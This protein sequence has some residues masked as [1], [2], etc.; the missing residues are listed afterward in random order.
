MIIAAKI[1]ARCGLRSDV[2]V[3]SRLLYFSALVDF[4]R[5]VDEDFSFE[6]LRVYSNNV[7][8]LRII[9]FDVN[10]IDRTIGAELHINPNL[11]PE[12]NEGYR[13]IRL[14]NYIVYDDAN[15]CLGR[16]ISV[17]NFG[18]GEILRVGSN[19]NFEYYPASHIEKIEE[20]RVILRRIA[21]A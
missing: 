12:D 21:F 8:L 19:S 14:L 16:V 7:H 20:E 6:Y 3:V 10:K 13:E 18:A 2:K 15:N 9:E 5:F 11:V 4:L 1:L 17:H